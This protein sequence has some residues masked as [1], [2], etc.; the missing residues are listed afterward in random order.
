MVGSKAEQV[1]QIVGREHP[2]VMYVY[3]EPQ[4]GTG[5]AA[6][7]AAE[8]L[9]N[10]GYGGNVLV[11]MGDKFI[12]EEAIETLVAGYV[13][14]QADMALLTLPLSKA[15]AASV[16]RVFVD[17]DGQALDIIEASDRVRQTMADEL[18]EKAAKSKR[19]VAAEILRV[20]KKHTAGRK[21]LDAAVAEL[22]ALAGDVKSVSQQKLE[23]IL[24]SE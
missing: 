5:H 23:E 13:K 22:V 7:V 15:T 14:Q 21:K 3:Q 10:L 4:L 19:L 6:K 16:G 9:Q 17:A 12:E 24:Q 11:T 1:L 20:V 18:R 8:A 2:G